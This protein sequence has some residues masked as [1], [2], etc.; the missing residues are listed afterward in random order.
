MRITL[1]TIAA[2][3]LSAELSAQGVFSNHTQTVLEKVIQDY[4]NHFYNIKGEQIAQA[5]QGV[6]YTSTVQLPG[7]SS[8][9]IT[10]TGGA[11]SSGERWA[12][13]LTKGENFEQARARF[14]EVYTQLSNC[15]IRNN[16]RKTFILTG[17]YEDPEPEKKQALVQ[18]SL[19]PAVGDLK[20]VHVVLCMKQEGSAWYIAL[21]VDDRNY[22][23]ESQG[24]MTVN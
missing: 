24:A 17:Q 6:Q 16:A 22:R 1:L 18:F 15:I 12:C 5:K 19:L 9:V 14:K 21:S 8:T 2:F 3:S 10:L 7:A 23:D 20:N 11:Q 4:P 13:T